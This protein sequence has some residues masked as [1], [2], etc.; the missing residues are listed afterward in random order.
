MRQLNDDDDE[1]KLSHMFVLIRRL[2]I[3]VIKQR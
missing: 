1:G 2:S 3:D